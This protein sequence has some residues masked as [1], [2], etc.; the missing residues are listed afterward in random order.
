MTACWNVS[1]SDLLN[2]SFWAKST[3]TRLMLLLMSSA[4]LMAFGA[5]IATGADT[6]ETYSPICGIPLAV[7]DGPITGIL[8]RTANG[9]A[10]NICCDRLGPMMA[11]TLATLIWFW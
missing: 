5:T 3:T 2:A 1:V 7:V 9:P 6:R 10:A 11:T 8:A 4:A